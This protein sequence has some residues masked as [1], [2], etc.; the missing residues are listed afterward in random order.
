MDISLDFHGKKK[1]CSNFD[2]PQLKL[3]LRSCF[4]LFHINEGKHEKKKKSYSYISSKLTL[5]QE[6]KILIVNDLAY[7]QK[8]ME[9]ENL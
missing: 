1:I 5:I 6:N 4:P 2:P 3:W 7:F 8:Q 9:E